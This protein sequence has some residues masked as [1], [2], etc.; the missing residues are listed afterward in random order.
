MDKKNTSHYRNR[1]R[2]IRRSTRRSTKVTCYGGRIGGSNV[3]THILDI[4][5]T[6]ARLRVREEYKKNQEIEI[7]LSSMSHRK[8]IRM[9][10]DVV[11]CVRT[12]EGDFCIGVQFRGVL[13]FRDVQL[14]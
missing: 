3:A 10:G 14:L 7:Y 13:P 12:E 9:R 2:S 1:R 4:S 5:E 6:G 8:P 11:W